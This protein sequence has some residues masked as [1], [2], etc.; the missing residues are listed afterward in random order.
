MQRPIDG[1]CTGTANSNPA[2]HLYPDSITGAGDSN[3]AAQLY[4]L[5]C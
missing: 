2:A 5:A 1:R 3:P 4:A